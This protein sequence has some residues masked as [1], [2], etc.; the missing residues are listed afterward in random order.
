MTLFVWEEEQVADFLLTKMKTV[1]P[2]GN[3]SYFN[4]SLMYFRT[5]NSKHSTRELKEPL[6]DPADPRSSSSSS[7]ESVVR[8]NSSSS[9]AS[10]SSSADSKR[11]FVSKQT[12]PADS[13]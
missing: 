4:F 1:I 6:H 2:L 12:L 11:S 13:K 3:N 8:T 5:S 9:V 7:V 10:G